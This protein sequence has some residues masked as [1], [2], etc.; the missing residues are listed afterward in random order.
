MLLI[1]DFREKG[2]DKSLAIDLYRLI[3]KN[4]KI[5]AYDHLSPR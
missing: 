4:S 2:N 5:L 3:N 1:L